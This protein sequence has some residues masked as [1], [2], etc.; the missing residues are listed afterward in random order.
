VAGV[1]IVA[2]AGP[3][4]LAMRGLIAALGGIGVLTVRRVPRRRGMFVVSSG[5]V[6]LA[7]VG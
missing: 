5:H 1:A 3:R 2:A 6:I 4:V 7:V